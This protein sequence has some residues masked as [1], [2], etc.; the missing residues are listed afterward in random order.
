MVI[1]DRVEPLVRAVLDAAVMRDTARFQAALAAF[2]DDEATRKGVELA[3]AVIGFVLLD[4]H[5]GK[6]SPDDVQA[7]AADISRQE[8]WIGP[9]VDEVTTFITALLNGRSLG[10]TLPSESVIV[11]AYV[12]AANLL[13]SSSNPD[14]G[15]W[16]FN[17]L[18][19]VEAAIESR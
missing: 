14:D 19:K 7:V 11:L 18:D 3:L 2:P 9:T 12:V 1:D 6:P 13:A 8:T 16:W 10:E 5:G 4:V 15:E 17:Y